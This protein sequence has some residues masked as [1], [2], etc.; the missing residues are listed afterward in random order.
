MP[1]LAALDDAMLR[2][3]RA[4]PAVNR[5]GGGAIAMAGADQPWRMVGA[6]AVVYQLRQPSGRVFALR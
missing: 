3:G 6:T 1:T 5:L 4:V 2:P